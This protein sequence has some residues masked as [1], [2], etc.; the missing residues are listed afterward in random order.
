MDIMFYAF[1]GIAA[2]AFGIIAIAAWVVFRRDGDVENTRIRSKRRLG[3]E[4]R[5]SPRR[6]MTKTR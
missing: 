1:G 6:S 4:P 5:S 3:K 2:V